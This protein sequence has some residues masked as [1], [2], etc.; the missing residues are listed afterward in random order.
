VSGIYGYARVSSI[1]QDLSVQRAALKAA[2]A[3]IIRRE[4]ASGSGRQGRSELDRLIQFL[5]W[6][7]TLIVTRIDRRARSLH[8]LS[9]I[10]HELLE[11]GVHL[12]C[13]GAAD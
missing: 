2:G 5:R 3:K 1:K 12:R 7:D 10:V 6:G 13:H 11:K 4:K 9:N 8:A